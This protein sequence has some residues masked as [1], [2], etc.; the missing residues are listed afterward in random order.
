MIKRSDKQ[1]IPVDAFSTAENQKSKLV[2]FL[3]TQRIKTAL[4]SLS[5]P[6]SFGES[7]TIIILSRRP[8]R[9]SVS[10]KVRYYCLTT[11]SMVLNENKWLFLAG[12]SHAKCSRL[13][14]FFAFEKLNERKWKVKG[15]KKKKKN[16]FYH[17]QTVHDYRHWFVAN[18]FLE[19]QHQQ[20]CL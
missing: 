2:F 16:H 20:K 13:F 11:L 18:I 9:R 1:G 10:K 4:R 12:R 19:W 3:S 14:F 15:Q 8:R 5:L 6:C 17:D 7:S